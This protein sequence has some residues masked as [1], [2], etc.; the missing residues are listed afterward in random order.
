MFKVFTEL[1]CDNKGFQV[2]FASGYTISVM[3]GDGNLADIVRDEHGDEG[4]WTAEVAVRKTGTNDFVRLQPYENVVGWVTPSH[5]AS[6][7]PACEAGDVEAMKRIFSDDESYSA[8][9]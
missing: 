2:G 5:V 9:E 4:V 6:L 1:E 8:S 3:F 7:M